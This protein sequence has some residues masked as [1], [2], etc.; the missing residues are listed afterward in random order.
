MK[1]L[2]ILF[3]LPSMSM[4]WD[5]KSNPKQACLD[6]KVLVQFSLDLHSDDKIANLLFC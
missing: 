5:F 3:L 6:E 1:Y 4:A 2:V